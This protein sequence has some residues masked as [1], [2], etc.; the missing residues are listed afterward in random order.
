[1]GLITKTVQ[2][3][4]TGKVIA[5]YKEKGYDAK[6]G[7]PIE[8]KIEDLS[9]GSHVIV[10]CLCDYCKEEIIEMEYRYYMKIMNE[11]VPKIT[12]KKCKHLK[13]EESNILIYN[14]SN[15]S[16]LPE[17][18]E[19]R[20]ETCL[21]KYGKINYTQTDEC[22]QR[23]KQT[24][25]SRYNA[26]TALLNPEVKQKG[27]ETL[28]ANYGVTN[29]FQSEEIKRRIISTNIQ[30]YG[31][32]FPTQNDEV[33]SKIR[34]TCYERYNGPAPISDPEIAAK[35]SETWKKN[36]NGIVSPF[37]SPEMSEAIRQKCY[38]EY[39][40]YSYSQVPE[41]REKAN[42]TFYK[43][44]TQKTSIQ[45]RMIYQILHDYDDDTKLNYPI[46][47]FSGDIVI[48]NIDFEIDYG[49]H[50]LSV[51]TGQLTQE[52]FDQK[53]LIRDKIIKSEGY[54]IVRLISEKNRK[55]PSDSKLIEIL[56]FSKAFFQQ[57]PERSWLEFNIE[58]GIYRSAL[59]KDGALFDFGELRT[60][61]KKELE[62]KTMT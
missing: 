53:Q 19:K 16:Q 7:V 6:H 51:K 22:K 49:G 5:Y 56:E 46:S 1:M 41:I 29:P 48:D 42:Q 44:V 45:Q 39:G 50:N 38:E 52:Q 8:V 27:I 36:H 32:S 54:K 3:V 62:S 14:V 24:C 35:I 18:I 4:P 2:V 23:Y 10:Q 11:V 13:I 25:I 17:T 40:V 58:K 47:N 43:N 60:V 20:R 31:S 21:Q 59:N 28:I 9:E 34:N 37:Q 26:N 12:C 15:I 33:K 61:K 57:N 30:R 55:I